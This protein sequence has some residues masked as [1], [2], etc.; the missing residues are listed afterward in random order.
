MRVLFGA[1]A[2]LLIGAAVGARAEEFKIAFTWG[3]IPRCTSGSPNTVP[4]PRFEVSGV[5]AGAKSIT[6]K[7]VDRDKPGYYHG[8]GK[9]PY[10]GQSVIEPGAFSYQSPCPPDGAHTYE[11]TADAD[12]LGK[13]KARA[14]YP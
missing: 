4:N 5:P 9:V 1:V 8:G 6:F 13:A 7:M 3:N 11:W 14:E 10:T 12:G 2:V